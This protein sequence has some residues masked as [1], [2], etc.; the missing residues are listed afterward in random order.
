MNGTDNNFGE[1]APG[2]FS[3]IVYDDRNNDGLV[4]S[5]ESGIPN[6]SVVLSGVDDR[7]ALVNIPL[8]T[9]ADGTFNFS[10]LRPGTHTITETTPAGF[11]DGKDTVG[12][13][14]GSAAVNDVF[15]GITLNAGGS[16]TNY[17]F[18]ELTPSSLSALVFSDLN[19][20]GTQDVGEAGIGGVAITLTGTDDLNNP[21]SISLNTLGDGTV[22][23]TNL[24]PGIYTITETQPGAYLDGKDTAGTLN[25]STAVNDVV[26]AIGIAP[27]QNGTGYRF[28]ELLPSSLSGNVFIDAN[29]DGIF[30]GGESA[31]NGVTVTLTGKD[32]LGN[33][34]NLTATTVGGAYTFN[35]LRPS[36][37]AGY[38]I[39]ET[40]PGGLLDGKMPSALRA[41]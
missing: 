13:L 7:G 6:A 34:V 29:N 4:D 23:F 5:G 33:N 26:S 38:T 39:T 18:G 20:N 36:D 41:A 24:R 40:Q 32:D 31:V 27:A 9:L 12:T 21:V 30:D 1:L 25:G 2:S 14:N 15:S 17:R 35:N 8:T 11:L 3:G 37:S 19:N 28:G 22:A 16:G 10:N